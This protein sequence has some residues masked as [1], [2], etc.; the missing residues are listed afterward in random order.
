MYSFTSYSRYRSVTNVAASGILL[1]LSVGDHVNTGGLGGQ[2]SNSVQFLS[3]FY[4]ID[5]CE[6]C[7]TA[8][9]LRDL[10]VREHEYR[11]I[12]LHHNSVTDLSQMLQHL[13]SYQCSP[14]EILSMLEGREDS[15]TVF[16][17]LP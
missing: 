4:Q 15:L 11:S 8:K 14:L 17:F 13:I 6:N 10:L 16:L 3:F 7:S 1:V 2:S 12:I 9:L 5:V